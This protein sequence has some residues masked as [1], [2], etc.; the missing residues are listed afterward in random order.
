MRKLV[1]G[2]LFALVCAAAGVATADEIRGRVVAEDGQGVADAVVFV[3]V[4]PAGANAAG[5]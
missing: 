5:G 2:S 1:A 4:L 3:T